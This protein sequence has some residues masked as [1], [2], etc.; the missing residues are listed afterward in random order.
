MAT[1]SLRSRILAVPVRAALTWLAFFLIV[2][3]VRLS[4]VAHFGSALAIMDQWDGEAARLFKPYFDGTLRVADLSSAHNEH[5]IVLSR[6]LALGLLLF[7]G[8]WDSRLEMAVTAI[9]CGLMAVAIAAATLRLMG[10][11]YRPLVLAAVACWSCFPY[12][13]ENT[14]WGFQSQFYFLL[15]FSLIALWGLVLH[16]ALSTRWFLGVAGAL[17]ACISMGSGFLCVAPVLAIVGLRIVTR[18]SSPRNEIATVVVSLGILLLGL[19]WLSHPAAHD[20]LRASGP[21]QWLHVFLSWLAWPF[22]DSPVASVVMYL[23][24][25]LLLIEYVR[26]TP[27]M[28]DAASGRTAELLLAV[29]GWVVLQSAAMAYARGA[30]FAEFKSARYTDVFACGA[31]TNLFAIALFCARTSA[32]T[33]WSTIACGLAAVWAGGLF[34][35]ATLRSVAGVKM[36]RERA[37]DVARGEERVRAYVA[38][39]DRQHLEANRHPYLPYRDPKRLAM[40]L[41]DPTI[42]RV[43]PA[44]VRM[45][46]KIDWAEPNGGAFRLIDERTEAGAAAGRVWR[47]DAGPEGVSQSAIVRPA[48]PY[49]EFKIAGALRDRMSLHLQNEETGKR[50]R[51]VPLK[52]RHGEWRTGYVAVPGEQVRVIARDENADA[53]FSFREPVEV[54]RLSYWSERLLRAAPYL[55]LT[56]LAAALALVLQ[57][58]LA[59]AADA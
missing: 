5:R 49:V 13:W 51:L 19:L 20:I 33:R 11:R 55:L 8:Q 37:A 21:A 24:L 31:L 3:G 25:G 54:G 57:R 32:A 56:G 4:L 29:G 12:A 14:V 38:T 35:G 42:R 18:R 50:N 40:L 6:L 30:Q 45:P 28:R 47:S 34:Y 59:R 2:V 41:D 17:L 46:L 22:L 36:M 26:T 1:K 7:N 23:P 16:T 43:L 9:I 53:S 39:G 15:F 44:A 27:A 52:R 58:Q 48:L 10:D